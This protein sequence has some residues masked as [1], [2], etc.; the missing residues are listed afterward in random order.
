MS[1]A[2]EPR[3]GEERIGRAFKGSLAVIALIATAAVALW[4]FSRD[5]QAPPAIEEATIEAPVQDAP[6]A[7]TQATPPGI[8]FTDITAAAGID[9]VHVNGAYGDKLIPETIG[10]GLAFFDYDNDGDPD[11][12]L[13]NSTYWPDRAEGLSVT[14]QF[15][16][17]GFQGWAQIADR[18][19]TIGTGQAERADIAINGTIA[20][21]FVHAANPPE[22]L[23]NGQPAALQGFMSAFALRHRSGHLLVW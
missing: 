21:L 18:Q 17:P 12:Y 9:F 15:D 13:V 11:L 7:P 2:P 10:S 1:A 14:A 6:T 20:D 23:E 8:P 16:T 5:G 4:W 3:P 22:L 19:M